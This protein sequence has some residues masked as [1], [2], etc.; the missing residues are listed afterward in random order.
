[1]K[2]INRKV[3]ALATLATIE[4]I[5]GILNEKSHVRNRRSVNKDERRGVTT[6][7]SVVG[8]ECIITYVDLLLRKTGCG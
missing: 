5:N 4:C 8:G 1:M 6:W 7:R 2:T 3:N